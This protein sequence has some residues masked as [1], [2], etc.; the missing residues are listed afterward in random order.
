MPTY[1]YEIHLNEQLDEQGRHVGW[2]DGYEPGHELVPA[3]TGTVIANDDQHALN[4]IFRIFNIDHPED[5]EARSL[6]VG[7]VVVLH[8]QDGPYEGAFACDPVGWR[9]VEIV[10]PVEQRFLAAVRKVALVEKAYPNQVGHLTDAMVIKAACHL[11]DA[12][13]CFVPNP[14]LREQMLAEYRAVL[15]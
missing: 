13:A 12:P 2:M 6:S 5:Y 11:A 10:S 4:E 9:E 8:T 3:Y 7:D 15:A 14:R 1:K